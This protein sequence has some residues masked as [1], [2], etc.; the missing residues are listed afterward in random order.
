MNQPRRE[1]QVELPIGYTDEAGRLH[2]TA[3]IRKMRG[4][5][6]ALFYDPGLSAGHLISE[7][8]RGCLVRLG[9]LPDVSGPVVSRLYSA[10]RNHLVVQ[11]RR[12]TLGDH[13]AARYSCRG[14]GADIAAVDD[15]ARIEVRRAADGDATVRLELEDGYRD[16]DGAVHRAVTLRLPRGEDEEFVAKMTDGDPLRMRDAML[17][18]C[19]QSF[20]TLR[21]AVLEG[22]G[23]K[24]LRD[25]TLGDRR[26]LFRA[27]DDDSPGVNFRR[28]VTCERC[29][30]SFKA[31][32]DVAGF[33]DLG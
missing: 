19:V 16:N 24:L 5:E 33:F 12:I 11:I 17:L 14:C 2:R 30:E 32:L 22:H 8:I 26:R 9:D 29:G 28:T 3:T 13:V 18:R 7:L 21:R 6:E 4:H 20:G 23:L 27:L 1:F 25:L 31:L 10:D 15:L